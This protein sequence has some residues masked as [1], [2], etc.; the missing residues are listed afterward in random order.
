MAIDNVIVRGLGPSLSGGGSAE[1]AGRSD[2]GLRN[3]N[4]TLVFTNNDWQ[5]NPAQAAIIAAAGLAPSNALEAAIAATLAAGPVHGAAGGTEQRHRQRVGGSV[6]PRPAGT[7]PDADS[8]ISPTPVAV[9][10]DARG[11]PHQ[12]RST[13][14]L[15]G[16]DARPRRRAESDAT[17]R[18]LRGELRW[19]LA[20]LPAGWVATND[21][22]PP[23]TVGHLDGQPRHRAQQRVRERPAVIS[24]KRLDT[25]NIVIS[26]AAAQLSFRNNYDFE[27]DPPPAE[28][29][30][31]GGVL[32]VST[33]G[34]PFVDIIDPA[35]GGSFVSGGYNGEIDGTANNPMA[36][37][38]A[39][40]ANSAGHTST[41]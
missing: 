4:G 32:E 31:D 15:T 7:V 29:F 6:R 18:E 34:G 41:R 36:A 30:W 8:G 27:Y 28:V 26:S 11:S 13:S 39:W 2:P 24:D 25:R 19:R 23:P 12:E 16:G 14:T 10:T 9:T 1:R 21:Q 17:G 3:A 37:Q 33:N 35:M 40:C 20:G 38:Q 22:G 5:D